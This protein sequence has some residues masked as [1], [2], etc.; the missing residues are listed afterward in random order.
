MNKES[1]VSFPR[2]LALDL[3]TSNLPRLHAFA[4]HAGLRP[5]PAF[6]AR[7]NLLDHITLVQVRR[8]LEIFQSI[9]HPIFGFL[10]INTLRHQCDLHWNGKGQG[11]P[12]EAVICGVIGL[13]SLFSEFLTP[14]AEAAVVTNA[15]ELLESPLSIH[16]SLQWVAAWILRTLYLR[17]TSRPHVAWLSSSITMHVAEAIGLHRTPEEMTLVVNPT[18][19]SLQEVANS[20]ERTF[21][22][23]QCVNLMISYD[24]GRSSVSVGETAQKAIPWRTGDFTAQLCDLIWIIAADDSVASSSIEST[25]LLT[26]L[27]RVSEAP[28]DHDFIVL[29]RA[30]LAFCIYRR[31]H[32]FGLSLEQRKA[33]QIIQAGMAS[34]QAAERLVTTGQPWWNIL[35]TVFHFVC[36]L[37]SI[38]TSNSIDLVPEAMRTL[39]QVVQQLN[40]H[41]AKEALQTAN[42]LVLASLEQKRKAARSLEKALARSTADERSPDDLTFPENNWDFYLRPFDETPFLDIDPLSV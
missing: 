9:I 5:E 22:V 17:A 19:Y 8:L 36:V 12:F 23:A 37:L 31:V 32:Y 4:Y 10:D 34:L 21:Q 2:S 20:R 35:G 7:Y 11:Q 33:D 18:K 24:Y 38:N 29:T 13:A 16:L 30:K 3:Q 1:S 41:M 27:T 14:Q 6:S 15:K 25:N 28:A 42:A 39:E 40:T 26:L